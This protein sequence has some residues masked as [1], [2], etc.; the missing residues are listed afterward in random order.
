MEL[1]FHHVKNYSQQFM[2]SSGPSL[3]QS[4]RTCFST[5]WRDSNNFLRTMVTT[6]HTLNTG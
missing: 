4:W 1:L 2:K 6:I 5:G 3:D